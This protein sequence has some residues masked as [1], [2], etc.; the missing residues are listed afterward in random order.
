[1]SEQN[2]NNFISVEGAEE[3]N[4]K[5]VSVRIPRGSITAIT[6]VSGAGKSTLAFDTILSEAYRKFFFTLSHYFR[7]FLPSKTKARVKKITGLSPAIGLSQYETRPSPFAS[8][9]SLTDLGELLG[10]LFARYSE[11]FCPKHGLATTAQSEEDVAEKIKE[12][13]SGK[14]VAICAPLVESKKGH[15]RKKLEALAEKGFTKIYCDGEVLSLS[16]TPELDSEKKHTLK[17]IIDYVQISEKTKKRLPK[18]LALSSELSKGY[19]EVFQSDKE[20]KLKPE[21]HKIFSF[22]SGCP[23]CGYSWPKLDSRHFAANSLGRCPSCSGLGKQEIL[24]D[25]A[26]REKL[27]EPCLGTGISNE[28]L[29]IKVGNKN[30]H[31]LYHQTLSENLTFI[32]NLPL[33]NKA[34]KLLLSEIKKALKSLEKMGLGYLHL[35]RKITSLSLGEHQ[36]TRLASVLSQDLSGIIYVLDEPSQ[37]LHA[38]EIENLYKILVKLKEKGNTLILVDHDTYLLKKSDW[39]IELGPAGGKEGGHKISEFKPKEASK[40]KEKSVT[41]AALFEEEKKV[42]HKS[43]KGKEAFIT[44]FG[45]NCHNLKIGK[46][47]FKKNALNVVSGVSGSGKTSLVVHTLYENLIRNLEKSAKK[48]KELTELKDLKGSEDILSVYLINRMPLA[49]TSASLVATYLGIFTPIRELFAS[50]HESK[51]AGLKSSDFSLRTAEGR[52]SECKGRGS[53]TLEMKFLED[54]EVECPLCSGKRYKLNVL[55]VRYNEK[56]IA[57]VLD[58]SIDEAYEFFKAFKKIRVPLEACQK[59]GLGYLKLGQASTQFSGGEAQRLKIVSTFLKAKKENQVLILDEPTRGL[60]ENDIK[61]LVNFLREL[62]N[63]GSTLVIIEHHLGLIKEAD[64]L[65]DL[66]PGAAHEGGKL[67]YG[68]TPEGILQ[69]KKASKTAQFL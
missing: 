39:L 44:L 65:I 60:H 11:A 35:F 16:P 50:S 12:K 38:S 1:M 10:V 6:G 55:S 62:S 29:G 47:S 19:V 3:H 61:Y 33:Q 34:H 56:S 49:K 22:Q 4:L 67:L 24:S 48:K 63:S 14:L 69:L 9:A 21:T 51:I 32:E 40:Y 59:I 25:K 68:G 18:S 43:T 26:S 52:C 28:R 37:G 23:T 17:L 2:F 30:I 66:G 54:A 64:W 41:A 36:R 15:F 58:F 42:F 7:Q 31:E 57:D 53:H 5:N 8:V 45:A 13:F 27:C 46:V 20:G